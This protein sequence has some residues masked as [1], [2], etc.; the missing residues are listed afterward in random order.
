MGVSWTYCNNHITIYVIRPSRCPPQTYTI[1][2]ARY[3]SIK[4][5]EKDECLLRALE[6]WKSSCLMTITPGWSCEGYLGRLRRVEVKR[7]SSRAGGKIE[8]AAEGNWRSWVRISQ[9][10]GGVTEIGHEVW[11]ETLCVLFSSVLNN[12]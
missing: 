8:G 7:K 3:F 9:E 1:M 12:P 4:L 2:Y 10:Y 5:G 11:P 6:S